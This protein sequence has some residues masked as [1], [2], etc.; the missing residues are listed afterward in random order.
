VHMCVCGND[1]LN[2]LIITPRTTMKN[3][4]ID[5][6]SHFI[7]RHDR[8]HYYKSQKRHKRRHGDDCATGRNGTTEHDTMP[9]ILPHDFTSH[10]FAALFEIEHHCLASVS[11]AR[12]IRAV[13]LCVA[14]SIEYC[15][16]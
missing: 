2:V 11:C 5:T 16:A 14:I 15:R 13:V 12:S 9:S 1:L 3:R 7:Y 8:M 6:T 4:L 10:R